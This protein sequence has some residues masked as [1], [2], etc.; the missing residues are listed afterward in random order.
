[1]A[2]EQFLDLQLYCGQRG[3]AALGEDLE[4]RSGLGHVTAG[5]DET[6]A[7]WC[8]GVGEFR[9]SDRRDGRYTEACRDESSASAVEY[10]KAFRGS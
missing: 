10:A 5:D 1:M 3:T 8:E 4:L 2:F 6:T 7:I 9:G